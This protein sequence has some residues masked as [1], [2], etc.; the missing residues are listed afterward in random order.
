MPTITSRILIVLSTVAAALAVTCATASAAAVIRQGDALVLRGEP[1]ELNHL[2]VADDPFEPGY[3]QFIDRGGYGIDAPP[4]QACSGFDTEWGGS[5]L[6]CPY[7]GVSEVILDGADGGDELDI[8]PD[9]LPGSITWILLGGPGDDDLEGPTMP[10]PLVGLSG[11]DGN[12]KLLGGDGDDYLDGGPGNDKLD[13]DDGSDQVLGGEG[14]DLLAGGRRAGTDL[15]DGGPG[16]DSIDGD[17]SDTASPPAP[18]DVTLDGVANDGR[19]GEGDNVIGVERIRLALVARLVAGADPVYFELEHSP[20][21]DSTLIGSPGNDRLAGDVGNDSI[22]G[23]AGEDAIF[24][25][26]GSDTID[27]RDGVHDSIDCGYGEA[28]EALVDAVD[29]TTNCERVSGGGGAPGDGA[30]G[31]GADKRG[32]DKNDRGGGCAVPKVKRGA[33]LAAARAKLRAADC[34]TKVVRVASG[35]PAGR[36]VSV[37]PAAGKKLKDGSKVE[38]RV[39]RGRAGAGRG[40]GRVA[41][42]LTGRAPTLAARVGS[43]DIVSPVPVKCLKLGYGGKTCGKRVHDQWKNGWWSSPAEFEFV[44][45]HFFSYAKLTVP[46]DGYKAFEGSGGTGIDGLAGLSGKFELPARTAK[47]P[48]VAAVAK[49]VT[50]NLHSTGAWETRDGTILCGFKATPQE[51]GQSFA[52]IIAPNVKRG[53]VDI[54]WS[55]VPPAFDCGG[56]S[57]VETPEF[58]D[59][60]PEVFQISYRASGF[61]DAELLKLPINTEWE[62]TQADGAHLKIQWFGYVAL[63]RVH[64][65]L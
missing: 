65:K 53:T 7:A 55:I 3:I 10:L 57:P 43:P 20:S 15:I 62:G 37:S 34:P 6:S 38:L 28:D 41:T 49:P 14:D 35:L 19:V 39:S 45:V 36:V 13:G 40:K 54:Q 16:Y 29:M 48:I 42:S 21:G 46:D 56:D 31:G 18:V 32:K 63:R 51:T 4:G 9:E 64:H 24:G 11:G 59:V 44:D 12:D 50:W 22:V 5:F 58:R 8:N 60:P 30:P 1:G 2:S 26:L 52:G 17:W 47:V 25:D 61:R 27:A 23:G 33:K